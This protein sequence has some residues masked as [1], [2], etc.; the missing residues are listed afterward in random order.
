MT[1][2]A[3]FALPQNILSLILAFNAG[4]LFFLIFAR[5]HDI[6]AEKLI[7][8]QDHY[9]KTL[10]RHNEALAKVLNERAGQAAWWVP[11]KTPEPEPERMH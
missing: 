1:V 3:L 2:G 4:S 9:I 11:P 7:D 6:S 10:E 5:L 8:A